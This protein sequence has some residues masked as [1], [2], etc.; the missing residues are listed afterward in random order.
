MMTEQSRSSWGFKQNRVL[1]C[2]IRPIGLFEVNNA[3]R[4]ELFV[5]CQLGWTC[6]N[7][8]FFWD[9]NGYVHD[10]STV[11]NNDRVQMGCP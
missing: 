10:H 6:L 9:K 8:H 3:E 5:D 1:V 7:G 4:R 2:V 11:S